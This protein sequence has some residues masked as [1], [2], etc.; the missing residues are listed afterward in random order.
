MRKTNILISIIISGLF[1]LS[2]TQVWASG[3]HGNR[4]YNQQ[5]RIHHGIRSGDL[6]RG[7]Y[8]R[9]QHEQWRVR[10]AERRAWS[11]R[12]LT[13]RERERLFRMR[14]R[15]SRHIYRAKH[16][17]AFRVP[18]RPVRIVERPWFW[19]PYVASYH[20]AYAPQFHF[21]GLIGDPGFSFGWSINVP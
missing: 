15:A 2:A 20:D 18:R 11:D 4:Q 8:R 6:T 16:N 5:K 12:R 1:L 17:R 9:L 14:D 7:E 3:R 19:R 13:W 10:H 21:G